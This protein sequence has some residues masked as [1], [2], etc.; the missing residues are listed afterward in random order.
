MLPAGHNVT[1]L[2]IEHHL[3]AKIEALVVSTVL[4]L[5]SGVSFRDGQDVCAMIWSALQGNRCDAYIESGS[6]VTNN[7]I[8]PFSREYRSVY[9][10]DFLWQVCFVIVFELSDAVDEDP[11]GGV[12][13]RRNILGDFG[14]AAVCLLERFRALVLEVETLLYLVS[15]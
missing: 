14:L 5:V 2:V 3:S 7:L 9:W 13:K 4:C 1:N 12:C 8:K 6:D 11:A 10:I 15:D